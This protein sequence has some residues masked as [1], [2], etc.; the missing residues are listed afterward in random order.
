[1]GFFKKLALFTQ[2]KIGTQLS[3]ELGKVIAVRKVSETR[4][5][6]CQYMLALP[7]MAIDLLNGEMASWFLGGHSVIL[8]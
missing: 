4:T 6:C 8:F 2:Q 7:R 1:M 5:Q 3:S